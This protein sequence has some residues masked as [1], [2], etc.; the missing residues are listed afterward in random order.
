M[1]FKYDVKIFVVCDD[2]KEASAYYAPNNL[3]IY[4]H[5]I[6]HLLVILYLHK[7]RSTSEISIVL[8]IKVQKLSLSIKC[9]RIVGEVGLIII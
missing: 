6:M 5:T 9:G 8:S 1:L 3:C 4:M 7:V 2:T